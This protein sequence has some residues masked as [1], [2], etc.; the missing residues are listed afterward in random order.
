MSAHELHWS[1]EMGVHIVCKHDDTPGVMNDGW[2]GDPINEE[3]TTALTVALADLAAD[4]QEVYEFIRDQGPIEVDGWLYAWSADGDICRVT[5][6]CG[7][8]EA[9]EWGVLDDVSHVYGWP[10]GCVTVPLATVDNV[11]WDDG[12]VITDLSP[13]LP[14]VPAGMTAEK[15]RAIAGWFDMLEQARG[16]STER[17]VQ[18]DLR[19]W[20]DHLDGEV[21]Q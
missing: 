9:A 13:I 5:S 12:P 1:P 21:D 19:K 4:E 2:V 6:W 7:M 17:E 20:A 8:S 18:T 3:E 10:D 15:L 11:D 14:A 16:V